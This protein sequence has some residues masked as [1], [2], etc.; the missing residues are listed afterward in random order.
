MKFELADMTVVAVVFILLV[1]LF[2]LAAFDRTQ[3]EYLVDAFKIS[4]G[5]VFGRAPTFIANGR[6]RT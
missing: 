1:G 2:A 6:N 3:P 4:I 5:A